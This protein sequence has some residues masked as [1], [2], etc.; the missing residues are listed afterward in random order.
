MRGVT[1]SG[2]IKVQSRLALI[3]LLECCY[4][5]VSDIVFFVRD[6]SIVH[7]GNL[8]QDFVPLGALHDLCH[9]HPHQSGG[10]DQGSGYYYNRSIVSGKLEKEA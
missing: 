5:S 7:G 8:F 4:Q 9:G 10:I 6:E 3:S 2:C 1:F